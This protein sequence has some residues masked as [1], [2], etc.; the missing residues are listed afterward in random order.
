MFIVNKKMKNTDLLQNYHKQIE[1]ARKFYYN[2]HDAKVSLHRFGH[3]G[4]SGAGPKPGRDF[5]LGGK[6]RWL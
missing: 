2:E 3:K 4:R 5:R 1:F 6:V